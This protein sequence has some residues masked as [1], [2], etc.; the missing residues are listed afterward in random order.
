MYHR[1][2]HLNAPRCMGN[3]NEKWGKRIES[4]ASIY[5]LFTGVD[6]L[7]QHIHKQDAS[8]LLFI[9]KI[10]ESAY[11]ELKLMPLNCLFCSQ[12]SLK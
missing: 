7:S 3:L 4:L 5:R 10:S 11:M 2:T 9:Y 8:H 12:S 1:A 6:L